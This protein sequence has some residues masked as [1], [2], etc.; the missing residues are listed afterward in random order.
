M[1][2][3]AK[4]HRGQ[5][6][7]WKSLIRAYSS[8]GEPMTTIVKNMAAERQQRSNSGER[9][10]ILSSSRREVER[11]RETERERDRQ[12]GAH[13]H[14][15]TR[16]HTRDRKRERLGIVWLLTPQSTPTVGQAVK[17]IDSLWGHSDSSQH[18]W[19]HHFD[20]QNHSC[21]REL[22]QT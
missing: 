6:N 7:F 19:N 14:A 10:C 21:N 12:T 8:E 4:R 18:R 3:A 2:I 11:G 15:C 20:P 9:A 22:L 16:K 5:G 1:S 13:T 17:Y